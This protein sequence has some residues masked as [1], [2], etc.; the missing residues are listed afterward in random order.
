MRLGGRIKVR[1]VQI[2]FV[3]TQKSKSTPRKAKLSVGFILAPQFTLLAFSAFVEALRLAADEGDRSR[4]ID[5]DWKVLSLD[6]APIVASSGVEIEPTH[7]LTDPAEF[8][9]LVVVGGLLKDLKFR[10]ELSDY[11]RRAAEASVPII[12][13]CT[14]SFVLAELGLMGGKKSC[15]SWYVAEDF[16]SRFPAL[17]YSSTEL[18]VDEGDRLTCAG[19]VSVVHLAAHIIERH[20]DNVRAAKVLRIMIAQAKLPSH[21]AQPMP[22]PI[23]N[24]LDARVRRAIEL[25]ERYISSPVTSEFLAQ[26]IGVS[27][28]QLERLFQTHL[29]TTPVAFAFQLKMR[30]AHDLLLTTNSSIGEVAQECG[31]AANSPFTRAFRQVYGKSPRQVRD[32][33][34]LCLE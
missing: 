8:D 1:A 29:G 11:I 28:R 3:E 14:G 15:I 2:S 16:A 26:K 33:K 9:Y 6:M 23:R 10:P 4:P 12:G 17:E 19:G 32:E 13:L 27:G 7:V 5:C 34:R 21:A 30:M 31:F 18:F 22:P 25:I 20:F 24:V